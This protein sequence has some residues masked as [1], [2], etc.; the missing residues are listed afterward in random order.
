MSSINAVP[1]PQV[2]LL[3]TKADGTAT[4]ALQTNGANALVIDASQNANC[5]TTGAIKI[6]VG[7]IA[8]RPASAVNGMVRFNTTNSRLEGYANNTWVT[9][10]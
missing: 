2:G 7:T 5:T 3:E 10:I 9:F 4:L 6:P 1:D 8:Q